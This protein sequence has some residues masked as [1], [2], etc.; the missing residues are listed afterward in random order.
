VEVIAHHNATTSSTSASEP[1]PNTMSGAVD[2]SVEEPGKTS[3]EPK[4]PTKKRFSTLLSKLKRKPKEE[5]ETSTPEKGFAGGA[6]LTGASSSTPSATAHP[7]VTTTTSH[8]AERSPSISS[9]S[10]DG[11]EQVSPEL[12]GRSKIR[13]Q[14]NDLSG[15]DSDE[16]EEARDTFDLEDGALAPPPKFMSKKAG[17]P[18][19]ETRFSEAL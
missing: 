4:S 7:A 8:D 12:R 14:Q 13:P 2:D 1:M 9:L 15:G 10:S 16:F 19:R 17:S 11:E 5:K 6:T 3:E 18:A